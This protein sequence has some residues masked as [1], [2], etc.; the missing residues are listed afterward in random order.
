M[1]LQAEVT[2]LLGLIRGGDTDA[3][4]RLVQL[5]LPEL[6]RIAG[7]LMRQERA[8]HTLQP[9]ALVNEGFL[10]L[11]KSNFLVEAQDRTHFFAAVARAMRQALV[12]HA[13]ARAAQQRGGGWQRQPLDDLVDQVE[14]SAGDVVHLHEAL[15]QLAG[16]AP[17]QVQVVEL[18]F[19]GGHSVAEV[20][21][22]L[23]VS[24]SAVEKDYTRARHFLLSRLEDA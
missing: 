3:P 4:N 23:G 7:S 19:F 24:V 1:T 20:A 2:T 15:D 6:R 22:M 11:F 5:V 8:D 21:E 18:R 14:Q 9:T 13:R 17:R 16:V 12:D 10:R